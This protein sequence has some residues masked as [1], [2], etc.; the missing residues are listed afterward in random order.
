MN[1]LKLVSKPFDLILRFLK[2]NDLHKNVIAGILV[3]L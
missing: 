3:P 2:D 1:V